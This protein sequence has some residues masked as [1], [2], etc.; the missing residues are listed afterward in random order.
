MNKQ[1]LKQ[2]DRCG[3]ENPRFQ[4]SERVTTGIHLACTGCLV[5]TLDEFSVL[6]NSAF[7]VYDRFNPPTL[8]N[9]A[10]R[11]RTMPFAFLETPEIEM[12]AKQIEA[13][14]FTKAYRRLE[15]DMEVHIQADNFV[16]AQVEHKLL[17][18]LKD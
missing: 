5:A 18:Y 1:G 15:A 6:L 16:K 3:A 13:N 14:L 11:F 8:E 12:L 7:T 2:C 9:L 4:V 10:Q 17:Q